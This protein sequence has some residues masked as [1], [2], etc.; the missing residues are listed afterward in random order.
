M[1]NEKLDAKICA[2]VMFDGNND[3]DF[4]SPLDVFGINCCPVA[5]CNSYCEKEKLMINT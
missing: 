4:D 1:R 3:Y 2:A 5:V